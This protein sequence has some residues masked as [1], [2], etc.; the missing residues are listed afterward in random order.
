MTTTFLDT[1]SNH[2]IIQPDKDGI[3][4]LSPTK[5]FLKNT[6]IILG[7]LFLLP[8]TVVL[9]AFFTTPSHEY[10]LIFLMLSMI[11]IG[12]LVYHMAHV[13]EVSIGIDNERL[14]IQSY[15][16]KKA[17]ANFKDI[18]FINEKITI[19][20]VHLQLQFDRDVDLFDN[21]QMRYYILPK[22]SKNKSISS[23][24]LV[25]YRLKNKEVD[26]WLIVIST[27]IWIVYLFLK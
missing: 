5:K 24:D 25:I 26:A 1:I 13:N 6:K 21:E 2:K 20:D 4:W 17:V 27:F 14:Y 23:L 22:L 10:L 16:R 19:D 7:A 3:I 18:T 11:P 9:V 8:V 15:F 12:F